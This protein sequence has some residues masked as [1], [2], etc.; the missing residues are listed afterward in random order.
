MQLTTHFT[1]EELGVANQEM[2]IRGTARILCAKLL[3]PVHVKFGKLRVTS[4]FRAPNHNL[5]V[6]GKPTSFHLY[7]DGK[8]AADFEPLE[9]KIQDVFDWIRLESELKFDKV[10]MESSHGVATVIHIQLDINERPRRLA[11]T[12]STGNGQQYIPQE[13]K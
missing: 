6:G 11:Y 5:L 3:E 1:E 2:R 7:Q 10:I 9:A 13:V 8:C 12:G 4:G